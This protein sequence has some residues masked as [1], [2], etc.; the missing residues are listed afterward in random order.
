MGTTDQKP[1]FHAKPSWGHTA[2]CKSEVGV[3]TS[4]PSEDVFLMKLRLTHWKN[5]LQVGEY[6]T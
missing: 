6:M 3:F 4:E 1:P 5:P 2:V